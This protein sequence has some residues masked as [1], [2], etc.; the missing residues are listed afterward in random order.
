MP[1]I[2]GSDRAIT[3]ARANVGRAGITRAGAAFKTNEIVLTGTAA[4]QYI[5]K[6]RVRP[7]TTWTKR[8]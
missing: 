3:T 5:W 1:S 8:R 7:T 4:G 6:T 2:S